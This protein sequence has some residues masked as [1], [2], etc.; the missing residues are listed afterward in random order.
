M[1]EPARLRRRRRVMGWTTHPDTL[2]A[3]LVLS[4]LASAVVLGW[5]LNSILTGS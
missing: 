1:S 3:I 2:A 4:F 5:G